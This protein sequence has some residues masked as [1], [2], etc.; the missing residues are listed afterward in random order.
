M[1]VYVEVLHIGLWGNLKASVQE[2]VEG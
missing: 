2:G 1:T